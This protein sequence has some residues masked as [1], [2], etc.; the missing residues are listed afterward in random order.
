[1]INMNSTTK[2]YFMELVTYGSLK[3]PIARAE[4]LEED[5]VS[6]GTQA[7]NYGIFTEQARVLTLN[8]A[9][10]IHAELALLCDEEK[11][12]IGSLLEFAP[13]LKE[14]IE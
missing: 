6:L 9:K 1:M 14:L 3:K 8:G 11:L 5:M 12:D 13:T 7:G 4:M 2:V 10:K